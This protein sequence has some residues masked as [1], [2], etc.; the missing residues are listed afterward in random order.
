MNTV[1]RLLVLAALV[2]TTSL[3]ADDAKF[4]FQVTGLRVIAPPKDA[5]KNARGAFFQ[6]GGV[7]VEVTAVPVSGSIVSIDQNDSQLDSFTDDKGTD[8]LAVK[9]DDPFNKPGFGAMDNKQTNATFEVQAAGVPA[10][11]ATALVLSGKL[12]LKVAA[13][14]KEFT[15]ENVVLKADT[16]FKCGEV[17]LKITKAGVSKAM[18][19]DKEE[20][21][22][23]FSS[24][25]DLESLASV[26]FFDA[27]GNKIEAHKDE[28]GGGMG[29]YFATYS[30]KQSLDHAKIVFAC[31]Q[32]LQTVK[33]PVS[34]KTGLGL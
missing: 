3:F 31:W 25:T 5:D 11:G 18:F 12:S 27:Q 28:W 8:L 17:A 9:S 30:L 6:P 19:S 26:D 21:S 29:E 1:S 13:S 23:T 2:S 10:K 24:A 15:V 4:S 14:T 33:V 22:V 16:A 7:A 20:F 32:N 34:V